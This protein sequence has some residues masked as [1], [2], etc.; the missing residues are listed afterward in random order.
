ML[1]DP[2]ELTKQREA[3]KAL[4]H[5]DNCK[6]FINE[7][8][9]LEMAVQLRDYKMD[10]SIHF[11]TE[12]RWNLH[13]LLVY[14]LMQTGPADLYMCMYA[15]KEYQAGL[16]ATMKNQT[17]I[18]EVHALLDYRSGVQHAEALQILKSNAD[19][20]GLMRTHAKLLVLRNEKWGVAITGSANLTA[21]T[22]C[23]AGVITCSESIAD[24]RIEYIKRKINESNKR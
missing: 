17:V 8:V 19:S 10:E 5:S 2:H 4:S 14:S 11:M 3:Y 15:V 24:Y 21:N 7:D 13:D 6:R 18:R 22:R 16:I 9:S 23:D 12:G 1:L 20:L